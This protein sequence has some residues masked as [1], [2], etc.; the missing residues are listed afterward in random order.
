MKVVKGI[1]VSPGI[2]IGPVCLHSPNV[3]TVPSYDISQGQIS[4][5]MMRFQTARA[6]AVQDIEV[7]LQRGK[8]EIGEMER[9]LLN[10]H[11][12][13]LNDPEFHEEVTRTLK[14][15]KKNVESVLR[16]VEDSLAKK[17]ESSEEEYL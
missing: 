11:L 9:K 4:D 8:P 14:E 15:R 10:S 17:L 6:G 13:M 1:M 7:L 5:E 16:E 2:A 12:L 3:I